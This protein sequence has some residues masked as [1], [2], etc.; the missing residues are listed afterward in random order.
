MRAFYHIA[1]LSLASAVDVLPYG[2]GKIR[3]SDLQ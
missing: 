3:R 2:P 1:L